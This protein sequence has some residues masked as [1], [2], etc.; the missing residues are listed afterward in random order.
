[1]NKGGHELGLSKDR[2]AGGGALQN[3]AEHMVL[4]TRTNEQSKRLLKIDKSR[5][6]D[7]PECYYEIQWDSEQKK[8]INAGI[9]SDYRKLLIG[10]DKKYKWER[11]L[12]MMEE[13]FT[14]NEFISYI[15][16][17]G[18]TSRTGYSWLKEMVSCNVIEKDDW[19][20]YNKRLKVLG[21][22]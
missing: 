8:L 7:Y 6:I 16:S 11:A 12:D 9:C 15:E 13:M 3:W 1:M 20:K 19:G 21:S 14:S 10:N 22:E 17:I 18:K 4:I 2:V 5:H